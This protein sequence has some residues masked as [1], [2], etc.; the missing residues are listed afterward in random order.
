MSFAC[1]AY[2][3]IAL[4]HYRSLKRCSSISLQACQHPSA[5]LDF[6]TKRIEVYTS[7]WRIRSGEQS[8]CSATRRS[9]AAPRISRVCWYSLR[10]LT[11][12]GLFYASNQTQPLFSEPLSCA[13]APS[14]SAPHKLVGGSSR[15]VRA[16]VFMRPFPQ[17]TIA[18]PTHC[19]P[20]SNS[21]GAPVERGDADPP[22][23]QRHPARH[24]QDGHPEGR[25]ELRQ[26]DGACP[27]GVFTL[28]RHAARPQGKCSHAGPQA[29][30]APG[31]GGPAHAES[32]GSRN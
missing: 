21:W 18:P 7:A 6:S 20:V 14:F 24:G 32:A 29:A 19:S 17:L 1:P 9:L 5:P 10:A 15:Q 26:K 23:G 27:Q 2:L 25:L 16:S 28:A 31:P 11:I 22:G 13:I 8:Q 12:A 3:R 4:H 30:G